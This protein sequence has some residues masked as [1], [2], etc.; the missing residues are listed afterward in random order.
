MSVDRRTN[1]SLSL[2]LAFVGGYGDAAGFILA[3]AFTGHVT[4]NLVLAAISVAGHDW[5]TCFRRLSAVAFFLTGILLSI[6]L[7]RFAGRRPFASS[8][9]AAMGT[10]LV[11]IAAAYF[12]LT[13]HVAAR[14][15]LFITCISLALG[16]QNGAFRR[17]GGISVHT[18]YLTGMITDLVTTEAEQ[19]N[20]RAIRRQQ[21]ASDP[22]VSLLCAIWSA[23]VLGAATG[24]AV[25]FRLKALGILGIAL[26]LFALMIR[27]WARAKPLATTQTSG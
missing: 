17:T 9:T 16:L 3:G 10:E 1:T 12:A 5:R 20:S 23:F 25:V 14:A 21:P 13:S 6:T 18:T 26:L 2:G 11:L 24:A 19:Y 4:G 8:L 27:L 7:E 15:E 22:K